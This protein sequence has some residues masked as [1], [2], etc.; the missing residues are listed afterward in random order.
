MYVAFVTCIMWCF[1]YCEACMLWH[2][3]C[4][5]GG[6]CMY[7]YMSSC[8]SMCMCN[9]V[10]ICLWYILLN[11]R[12]AYRVWIFDLKCAFALCFVVVIYCQFPVKGNATI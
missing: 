3:S 5:N 6:S 7:A 12:L 2:R 1:V 4:G 9:Y 8:T 11:T 10:Y